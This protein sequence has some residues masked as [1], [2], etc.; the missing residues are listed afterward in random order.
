MKD[1]LKKEAKKYANLN[2]QQWGWTTGM[3]LS[4]GLGIYV[5][6]N[7]GLKAINWEVEGKID[8]DNQFFKLIVKACVIPLTSGL[9]ANLFSNMGAGI[10]VVTNKTTLLSWTYNKCF[11]NQ[12]EEKVPLRDGYG[13][14][15][16]GERTSVNSNGL[17]Q[18]AGA[19]T[20]SREL[21]F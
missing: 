18:A 14:L 5:L 13:T 12:Q 7:Y 11:K 19:V 20:A 4:L 16:N 8:S 2:H 10:D 6:A 1:F 21:K 3:F 17:E 15:F 9:F